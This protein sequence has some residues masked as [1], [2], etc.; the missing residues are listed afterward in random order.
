MTAKAVDEEFLDG[1]DLERIT[2]I[3]SGTW[4]YWAW[5]GKCPPGIKLGRRRVWRR[6]VINAWIKEQEQKTA[7]AS[8]THK[9]NTK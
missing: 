3:K 8:A 9:Q 1:N 4:R 5:S 7:Q 6:S 2:G